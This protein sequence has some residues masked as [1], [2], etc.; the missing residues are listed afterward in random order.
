MT[1]ADGIAQDTVI[2]THVPC[3]FWPLAVPLLISSRPLVLT[4]TVWEWFI[5]LLQLWGL[6][7][8]IAFV[9]DHRLRYRISLVATNIICW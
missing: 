2:I 8:D 6:R 3:P 1:A 4:S 7:L 5:L 9:T